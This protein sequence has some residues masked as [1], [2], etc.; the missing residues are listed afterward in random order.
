MHELME[1]LMEAHLAA[2]KLV[3]RTKVDAIWL[4]DDVGAQ[5][6][7]IMGKPHWET[8]L[9]PRLARMYTAVRESGK[10]LGIHTCGDNTEIIGEYIDMGVQ[11]IDPFQP[12][13]MDV[14]SLKREYGSEVTFKGGIGTQVLLPHG[15][16]EGIRSEINRL[17]VECGK[18]GGFILEPTKPIMADVPTANA[19]AC[20][21]TMI[22]QDAWKERA[23]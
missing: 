23:K 12:E 9:K 19:V 11:I 3:A 15:N 6:G 13:A 14:Y 18:G 4:G 16:P 1:G 22:A 10:V 21:E 8:Y 7:L 17:L 5:K 20:I 2:I